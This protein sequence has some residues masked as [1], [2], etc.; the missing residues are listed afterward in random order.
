MDLK[1]QVKN[2]NTLLTKIFNTPTRLSSMLLKLGFT[3]EQISE[4][5][6]QHLDKTYT[7]FNNLIKEVLRTKSTGS[8]RLFD[9]MTLRY[10]LNEIP[11]QTLRSIGNVMGISGQR[12]SQ[13]ET[14]A[15]R[16]LRHPKNKR[17]LEES[18]RNIVSKLLSE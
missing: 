13:L 4:I 7:L 2:T 14:K 1:L 17:R 15:L 10:G 12:V 6:Y 3:P 8:Y 16:K 18:L 11:S 5:R 9:L